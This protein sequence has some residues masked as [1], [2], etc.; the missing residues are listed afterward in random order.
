MLPISKMQLVVFAV[1]LI[2]P[3][4]QSGGFL[5]GTAVYEDCMDLL[6]KCGE[7]ECLLRGGG[8]FKDYNPLIS[9]QQLGI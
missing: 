2:L 1:V 7:I 9:R 4:L 6:D 8:K 3:A 5:S